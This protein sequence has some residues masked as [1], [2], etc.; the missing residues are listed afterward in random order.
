MNRVSMVVQLLWRAPSWSQGLSVLECS[1]HWEALGCLQSEFGSS[2]HRHTL[3]AVDLQQEA[4]LALALGVPSPHR[5]LLAT[6]SPSS[7]AHCHSATYGSP[8][9]TQLVGNC[10]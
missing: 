1:S 2:T 8:C 4:H 10:T 6:Q 9:V 7:S 3:L 5:H